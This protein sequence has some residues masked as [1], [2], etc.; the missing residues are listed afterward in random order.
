VS[1]EVVTLRGCMPGC[2]EVCPTRPANALGIVPIAVGGLKVLG[3]AAVKVLGI[4]TGSKITPEDRAI[5]A[6]KW[7]DPAVRAADFQRTMSAFKTAQV[8]T[9]LDRV[10]GRKALP[11]KLPRGMNPIFPTP[12]QVMTPTPAPMP[13][14][15][16]VA[17]PVPVG[18]GVSAMEVPSSMT[19]GAATASGGGAESAE[20]A[21][22]SSSG[23]SAVPLLIG[24]LLLLFA[25]AKRHPRR[26]R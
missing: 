13:I 6:Q 23:F 2:C 18:A 9:A 10:M 26:N 4:P 25:S 22:P 19:A 1:Y 11:G 5:Q 12:V 21:A 3:S 16:V 7:E 14:T 8:G 15:S 17:A 24:G 20:T